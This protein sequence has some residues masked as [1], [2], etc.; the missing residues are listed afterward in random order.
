MGEK[1][2]QVEK[3]KSVL[4][5]YDLIILGTP[6]WVKLPPAMRTLLHENPKGFKKVAFYCTMGSSGYEK[7]FEEMKELSHSKP[8]ATV[9][10]TDEE[11]N[12][13]TYKDMIGEFVKKIS[14]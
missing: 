10:I 5:Q 11:I 12:E 8:L 6:I 9:A 1:L 2:T 14:V 4:S 7:L 13:G 3:I